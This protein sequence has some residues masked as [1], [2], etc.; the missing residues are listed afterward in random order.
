MGNYYGGKDVYVRIGNGDGSNPAV[1][2]IV[3]GGT[4]SIESQNENIR[5][6]GSAKVLQVRPGLIV[7]S[8]N[9]DFDL[10]ERLLLAKAI[11][12][13]N[14][15]LPEFS[16][17]A[18]VH[19]GG[20]LHK[21]CKCSELSLEL[22]FKSKV[23]GSFSWTGLNVSAGTPA[24][25]TPPSKN[26]FMWYEAVIADLSIIRIRSL[27][28]R[29]SHDLD[30]EGCIRE[31][32]EGELAREGDEVPEGDQTIECGIKIF[33]PTDIDI[34]ADD[35]AE[36]AEATIT[37]VSGDEEIIINLI[38]LTPKKDEYPIS[39][40][41]LINFGMDFDVRDWAVA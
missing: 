17:D 26:V 18:G 41:K 20:K 32:A 34:T 25:Q 28:L 14:D 8:G 24:V 22:A 2:G 7:P 21:R 9:I 29:V 37:L 31:K 11:R 10:Q 12:G 3:T 35:L 36:I 13:T 23:S 38:G 27:S 5:G 1:A 30:I 19:T 40:D 33:K 39:M 6:V 4:H 15:I 16:I